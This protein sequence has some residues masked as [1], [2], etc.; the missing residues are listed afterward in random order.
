MRLFL[1]LSHF[2]TQ[3]PCNPLRPLHPYPNRRLNG[4]FLNTAAESSDALLLLLQETFGFG[5]GECV[6]RIV[7]GGNVGEKRVRLVKGLRMREYCS[8]LA[9]SDTSIMQYQLEIEITRIAG[10]EQA[11]QSSNVGQMQQ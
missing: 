7:M 4:Y 10:T 11:G 6:V 5:E 8:L 2:N 1:H 9:E 3:T